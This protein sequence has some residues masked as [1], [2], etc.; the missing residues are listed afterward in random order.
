MSPI[1]RASLDRWMFHRDG[2]DY[3]PFSVRD[4]EKMIE[5][6][7]LTG[8]SEIINYRSKISAPVSKV[9]HFAEFLAQK[10]ERDRAAAYT[11][12]VERDTSQVIAQARRRRHGPLVVAAVAVVL[13]GLGSWLLL[14]EPELPTSGYPVTFFRDL[15]FPTV[16]AMTQ[17]MAT[18]VQFRPVVDEPAKPAGNGI[19]RR[20]R[21]S[22]GDAPGVVETVMMDM[23]YGSDR[24]LTQADIDQLKAEVTPGLIRCFQRELSEVEG[25]KGGK[26][27]FLMMPKGKVALSRV[28]TR[29]VA[30]KRLVSCVSATVGSKKV[31]PYAGAIQIIEFPLHVSME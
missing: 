21:R 22:D 20:P 28:D 2:M 29:P 15:A 10:E 17:R 19:A 26:V 24:E 9:P 7:E 3:G 18:P 25:F 4:I 16:E 30:S 23:S 31:A 13:G 27:V 8:Q 11:A 12:E 6:G 5:S 1:T 14:R